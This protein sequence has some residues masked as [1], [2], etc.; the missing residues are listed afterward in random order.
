V[1][2]T[3]SDKGAA[4]TKI[5]ATVGPSTSTSSTIASLLDAGTAV[6]R[7]NLSHGDLA[8]HRELAQTIRDA[9]KTAGVP[10]AAVMF[11]TRGAEVRTAELAAPVRLQAGDRVVLLPAGAQ[12]TAGHTDHALP[13]VTT[14]YPGLASLLETGDRIL[15]DDGRVVILVEELHDNS[16]VCV[17]PSGAIIESHKKVT[18]PRRAKDLPVLTTDDERDLRLAAELGVDFVAASFVGCAEDII[19]VRR[20][21]EEHGAQAAVI[22]KIENASAV[23]NVD[24][25]LEAADGIMIARGDLGVELPPE[26]VP[27][28]QKDLIRRARRVGKPVITATQMLE[29]MIHSPQPT[30]AEASDVANAILDGTDAIMLSGETAVGD[31]P[32]EAVRLMRRIANRAERALFEDESL[33]EPVSLHY[34]D[35]TDAIS[36]AS[37]SVARDLGTAAIITATQSGYTAR[38]VSR[39]RPLQR[40]IAATPDLDVAR[41]LALTWGVLPIVAKPKQTTD[42]MMAEAVAAA[43]ERRLVRPG[44]LVVLTAGVPVGTPGTTNMLQVQLVAR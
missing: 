24:A 8:Q 40:V 26:E 25:V 44:E 17:A 10:H 23:D 14:T 29:S 30:R 42:E 32:V 36:H 11:D 18:L 31:H 4:R 27:I 35:V 16:V 19:A 22:A 9:A 20:F 41:R 1:A 7:I 3:T 12:P 28:L 5:V 6:L 38:M 21:L 37:C 2:L 13:H 34:H 43:L 33:R 39:H 15:I